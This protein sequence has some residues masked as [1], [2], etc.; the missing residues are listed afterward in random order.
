MSYAAAHYI[1]FLVDGASRWE[2]LVGRTK[3]GQAY[4]VYKAP[5]QRRTIVGALCGRYVILLRIPVYSKSYVVVRHT[6]KLRSI[7][8]TNTSIIPGV[9][10]ILHTT[11]VPVLYQ[12]VPQV[13]IPWYTSTGIQYLTAVIKVL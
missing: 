3:N 9:Y 13:R 1:L 11:T 2:Y 4:D 8:N 12:Q 7:S 6:T 10:G 5:F